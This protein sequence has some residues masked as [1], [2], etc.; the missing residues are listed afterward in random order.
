MSKGICG[1]HD[2]STKKST[3]TKVL[4]ECYMTWHVTS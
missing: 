4:Q 1:L 2:L 3:M